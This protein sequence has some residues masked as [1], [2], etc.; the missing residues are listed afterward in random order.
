MAAV[1]VD[2]AVQRAGQTAE[3][4]S[5]QGDAGRPGQHTAGHGCGRQPF[6]ASGQTAGRTQ[7]LPSLAAEDVGQ[8]DPFR[9]GRDLSHAAGGAGQ[10][11]GAPRQHLR[12]PGERRPARKGRAPGQG[13][14]H[15]L[16]GSALALQHQ[17]R[18]PGEGVQFGGEGPAGAWPVP[19]ILRRGGLEAGPGEDEAAVDSGLAGGGIRG[20][21]VAR[22]GRERLHRRALQRQAVA[23]KAVELDPELAD[24]HPADDRRPQAGTR[25]GAGAAD[26]RAHR[27]AAQARNLARGRGVGLCAG[28]GGERIH[29]VFSAWIL[30]A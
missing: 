9:L 21:E 10:I 19:G 3:G 7:Q 13:Q 17:R 30:A 16:P 28:E 26:G 23:G 11:E 2:G 25:R 14:T 18:Q 1:G 4:G 29:A 6:G 5:A 20:P 24:Q 12:S 8:P 22:R 15:G 27:G